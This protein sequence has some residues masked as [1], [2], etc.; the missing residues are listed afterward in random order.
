M[1][2]KIFTCS[3]GIVEMEKRINRWLKENSK[4]TIIRTMQSESERSFII[5]IIYETPLF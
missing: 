1:F 2:I 3:G 4:I 5:S